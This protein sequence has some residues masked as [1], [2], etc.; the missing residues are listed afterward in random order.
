M[1]TTI[2]LPQP[3]SLPSQ[4]FLLERS[5]FGLPLVIWAI[6][7]LLIVIS[8]RFGAPV[9]VFDAQQLLAL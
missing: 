1:P 9:M 4:N 8:A 7:V 6:A 5:V 3:K 2:A